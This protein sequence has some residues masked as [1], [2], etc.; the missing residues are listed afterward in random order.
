MSEGRPQHSSNYHCH[1]L[2]GH[3]YQF[4]LSAMPTNPCNVIASSEALERTLIGQ[5]TWFLFAQ[6]SELDAH[7]NAAPHLG[8]AS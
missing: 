8:S 7:C 5:A 4:L 3:T 6:A 1:G 2:D